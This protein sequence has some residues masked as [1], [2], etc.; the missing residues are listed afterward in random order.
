MIRTRAIPC[1]LLRGR[2]FVKTVRFSDPKYLGDPINIVPPA[3]PARL[4][5]SAAMRSFPGK[6]CPR[7]GGN[8]ESQTS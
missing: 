1:L 6:K 4:I 8:A 3:G 5:R 7:W 2:G